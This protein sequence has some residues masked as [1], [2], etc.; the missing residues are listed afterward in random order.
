[1]RKT[2]LSLNRLRETVLSLNR[3]R[4]TVL[5]LNRLRETVLSLNRLRETV[6]SLNR[7]RV[8]NCLAFQSFY[9]HV[10]HVSN[11]GGKTRVVHTQLEVYVLIVIVDIYTYHTYI[12]SFK[13]QEIER[14]AL[15]ILLKN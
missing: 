6:L 10:L 2:V 1:L 5:S 8:F 11:S 14:T 4:E 13:I 12:S 15:H 7:L 9:S 3:L